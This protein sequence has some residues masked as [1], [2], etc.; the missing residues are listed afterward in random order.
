MAA[1]LHGKWR[2]ACTATVGPS[3][4]IADLTVGLDNWWASGQNEIRRP[5]PDGTSVVRAV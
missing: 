5:R 4:E 1:S 3:D 2:R